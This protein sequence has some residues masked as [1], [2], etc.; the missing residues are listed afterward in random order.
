MVRSKMVDK[1]ENE[2]VIDVIDEIDVIDVVKPVKPEA[3]SKRQRPRKAPNKHVHN[4]NNP[5]RSNVKDLKVPI[6]KSEEHFIK[7][8]YKDAEDNIKEDI[9]VIDE[10]DY[11]EKV[12]Y[13]D[14]IEALVTEIFDRGGIWADTNTIVPFHRIM[15]FKKHMG[16]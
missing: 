16:E 12:S 14:N 15:A 11:D 3:V 5:Q 6:K 2:N 4:G 13:A 1:N 7:V 8:V 9:S 10:L